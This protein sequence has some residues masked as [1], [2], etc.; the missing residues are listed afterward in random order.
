MPQYDA[1][2]KNTPLQPDCLG[3]T[4]SPILTAEWP[5]AASLKSVSVSV[6][7]IRITCTELLFWLVWIKC[8]DS[9]KACRIGPDV[10]EVPPNTGRHT[11]TGGVTYHQV[12]DPG[13]AFSGLAPT[14]AVPCSSDF[15]AFP[16]LATVPCVLPTSL[17]STKP[18][19]F[20]Q[21]PVLVPPPLWCSL[22]S[23]RKQ[24]VLSTVFT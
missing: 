8:I 16:S 19:P 15:G 23:C 24:R 3:W 12:R 10:W 13:T 20:L 1:P 21:D 4:H 22:P 14:L 2:D 5:W 18:L 11:V 17:F 9:P 6:D 7:G